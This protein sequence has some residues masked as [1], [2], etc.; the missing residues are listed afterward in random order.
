MIRPTPPRARSAKYSASR[1][2]SRARSSSPVCIEPITTLLRSVV[3]PRSN[4]D[5]RFG[6]GSVAASSSGMSLPRECRYDFVEPVDRTFLRAD[7]AATHPVL[8]QCAAMQCP[9]VREL[10]F[11]ESA[12]G[13]EQ[14]GAFG[15]QRRYLGAQRVDVAGGRRPE[16]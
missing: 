11:L 9:R 2:V 10:A 5:N 12:V 6:Y 15:A 13:V 7:A 14:L 8:V 1:S 3:N 16:L 4:G